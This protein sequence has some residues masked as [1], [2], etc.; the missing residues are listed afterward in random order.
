[1]KASPNTPPPIHPYRAAWNPKEYIYPDGSLVKGNHIMGASIVDPRTQTTTHIEIKSQPKRHTINRAEL[2]AIT[3]ALEAN[4]N[5][6]TLSII[7][8][9]AF[10]INT[11]RKYAKDPL[12]FNHHPH[13]ERTTSSAQETTWDTSHTSARL[14]HTRESHTMT[15]QTQ[16]RAA[17]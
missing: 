10:N 15:K 3:L 2:A 16:P 7:T 8:D 14:N 13:K 17:L 1:M 12:C 6:H 11:I 9:S 5:D 4:K